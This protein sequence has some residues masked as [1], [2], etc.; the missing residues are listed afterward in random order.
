M[1]SKFTTVSAAKNLMQSMEIAINNMIEE[2][3]KRLPIWKKEHY[4]DGVS[5]WVKG[6]VPPGTDL[7]TSTHSVPSADDELL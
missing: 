2:I 6:T 1:A 4:I 3:K 7:E 5:E